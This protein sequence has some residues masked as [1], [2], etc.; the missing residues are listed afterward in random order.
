MHQR[1]AASSQKH[2]SQIP[3]SVV[4]SRTLPWRWHPVRE[5][6]RLEPK[7]EGPGS[8][9]LSAQ[10]SLSAR[11]TRRENTRRNTPRP[12][13]AIPECATKQSVHSAWQAPEAG[14]VGLELPPAPP[15]RLHPR[16]SATGTRA[17]S[18]TETPGLHEPAGHVA[19]CPRPP[20]ESSPQGPRPSRGESPGRAHPRP[21]ASR[22]HRV[23]TLELRAGPDAVSTQARPLSSALLPP[24]P[25]S[26]PRLLRRS[27][28]VSHTERGWER[29]GRAA[30]A[31]GRRCAQRGRR[32]AAASASRAGRA[33]SGRRRRRGL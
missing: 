29:V 5:S 18:A 28:A 27:F 25:P 19:Q 23:A 1:G 26:P 22:A 30:A 31:G 16:G 2:H 7:G 9:L 11:V 3:R 20:G 24:L 8:H 33:P 6:L 10:G 21:H 32:A 17:N 4:P 14:A 12:H 15:H 13:P